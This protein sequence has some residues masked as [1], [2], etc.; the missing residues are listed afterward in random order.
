MSKNFPVLI[1]FILS[2]AAPLGNAQ[3][4]QSGQPATVS[5]DDRLNELQKKMGEAADK[6]QIGKYNKYKHEAEKIVLAPDPDPPKK[7]PETRRMDSSPVSRAGTGCVNPN[8]NHGPA[9]SC[10]DLFKPPRPRNGLPSA[11]DAGK[12]SEPGS[13]R[14]PS[15]G[16]AR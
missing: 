2:M 4:V 11:S 3:S 6:G 12:Y 15:A 1:A 10:E 9:K 8:A 16:G 14:P 13:S 7:A 5:D